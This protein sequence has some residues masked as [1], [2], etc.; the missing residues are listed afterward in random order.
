MAH[1]LKL[2]EEL[3][4]VIVS[5]LSNKEIKQMRL[6]NR[7]CRDRLALRIERVYISPNTTNLEVFLAILEHPHYRPLI[8]EII[9]DDALLEHYRSPEEE[10]I[11]FEDDHKDTVNLLS[12]DDFEHGLD[13][14]QG[15]CFP[16][17]PK[18]F[19]AAKKWSMTGQCLE[20]D[21]PGCLTIQENI[22]IYRRLFEDQARIIL[23]KADVL[24]FR[25]GLAEFPALQRITLTS[26]AHGPVI[27]RPCHT[28]PMIRALPIN[29]MYPCPYPC[30]DKDEGWHGMSI[31][32]DELARSERTLQELVIETRY[33]ATGLAQRFF[34]FTQDYQNL[35]QVLK[36][37][38][39]RR[40]DLALDVEGGEYYKSESL[41]F[42][43]LG[44]LRKILSK[45]TSMANFSLSASTTPRFHSEHIINL[46]GA[47]WILKAIPTRRW[48]SLR[49]LG[50]ANFPLMI[51]DFLKFL[52][53]LP[54]TIQSL[55]FVDV[56]FRENYFTGH[57][58]LDPYEAY[59]HG[60]YDEDANEGGDE[61][62]H[63]IDQ[64]IQNF[65]SDR[66]VANWDVVLEVCR[67]DFRYRANRPE[68]S[69]GQCCGE[70]EYLKRCDQSDPGRPVRYSRKWVK[71]D[72]A[73]FF[74][75]GPNPFV[76]E[77]EPSLIQDGFGLIRDDYD[78][79]HEYGNQGPA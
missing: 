44:R 58:Q 7:E 56:Q 6:A 13:A 53:N 49:H 2:P 31:I 34:D 73:A 35:G 76:G 10:E 1:L 17:G 64:S 27:H 30:G 59:E 71:D 77:K 55:V 79:S 52:S 62:D 39:L 75:G 69:V 8:R 40:L 33:A 47:C 22:D 12:Y 46:D 15:Q 18:Q 26:V 63:A 37:Q 66:W 19:A 38:G 43:P 57:D 65:Q 20:E 28:T 16:D 42:F 36:A 21:V 4:V 67:A 14:Y 45:A 3:F 41:M 24:A 50:L 32:L 78:D 11:D 72:I 5:L 25:R 29:F 70:V 9:W 51:Q 68:F 54:R 74:D 23:E 60:E 48:S 61:I